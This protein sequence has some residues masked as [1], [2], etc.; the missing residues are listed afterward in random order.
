MRIR[1]YL[2]QEQADLLFSSHIMSPLAYCPLVWMFCSKQAHNMIQKT[3]YK[4][5]RARFNDFSASLE[6]LIERANSC[7]IHTRNLRFLMEEVFKTLKR[8][9]ANIMWD[10]FN[11]KD[12][13]KYELRRGCNLV[14]PKGRTTKVI[15]SFDFRAALAWNHLPI[16]VKNAENLVEFKK[17]LKKETIYCKCL[18]CT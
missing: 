3:Q 1:N 15:N 6:E 16:H 17:I 12:P 8:S 10:S 9:N 7:S 5:L 4:G 13:N 18:N 14:I 2:N 11:F